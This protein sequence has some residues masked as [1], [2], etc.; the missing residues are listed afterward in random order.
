MSRARL[1]QLY[2]EMVVLLPLLG[3]VIA[4]LIY[5]VGAVNHFPGG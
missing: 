2:A 1:H 3:G 4:A 5:L